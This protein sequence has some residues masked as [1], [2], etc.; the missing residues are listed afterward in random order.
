VLASR[1]QGSPE[2]QEALEEVV[3]AAGSDGFAP[4]IVYTT[5]SARDRADEIKNWK[6]LDSEAIKKAY[7][8]R[9]RLRHVTPVSD[10]LPSGADD[11]MAFS[12]WQ[13]YVPED[14]PYLTNY[15]RTAFDFNLENLGIFLQWLFPGT[16]TYPGSPI[17]FAE[18]FYSP[19]SDLVARLKKAEQD[20]VKWSP[21]HAAAIQR[22]LEVL[23]EEPES[24][25]PTS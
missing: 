8:Q 5:V 2:L 10:L 24:P 4:D 7:G 23:K 3:Q 6:G 12:R 18:G 19:L 22:F 15:L 25:P 21:E 11:P 16:I 1:F 14:I 20:G 9:M 13:F 17:K